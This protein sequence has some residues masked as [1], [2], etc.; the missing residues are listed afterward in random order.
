[1]AISNFIPTVWSEALC[2]SL[3]KA[4]IGV[5]HCTREFEGDIKEKGNTVKICGLNDV[6]VYDYFKNSNMRSAEALSD[7][8]TELT[9]NYAKYFNFQIDDI[10]HAQSNPKL[11]QLA[12][13]NAANALAAEA[14]RIVFNTCSIAE[15]A[16]Q[17]TA[18]KSTVIHD[19]ISAC[20]L[21][22]EF[23]GAALDDVVFEVSPSV[24]ALITEAKLNLASDNT[25][26][27]ETGCIGSIA[28]CKVFVTSQINIGE[29]DNCNPVHRC[30]LRST[31]AV[32][33]AEQLSEIH[34]Y[35]P[36][37]RFADAV[38][39][40]HLYGCKIVRPKEI[41]VVNFTFPSEV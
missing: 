38:K 17:A 29:D 6:S 34:A 4:Y 24:A 1:M 14:D 3:D 36:E 12:L 8:S 23:N 26:M 28:G 7:F 33:F 27:L 40:L 35:R 21:L 25:K 37:L 31:R 15:N 20:T 5:A 10:D 32:A 39:G 30:I 41:M 22:Q 9:I 19:I 2:Q 13:K 16:Y 11:M 18:S